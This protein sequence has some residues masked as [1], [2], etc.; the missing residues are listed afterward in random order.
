MANI[1]LLDALDFKRIYKRFKKDFAPGE[2][3]PYFVL[4]SQI[5]NG[6]QQC[7]LF[8]MD[9]RESAY[10][11]CAGNHMNE[12]VLISYLAVYKE[13]RGAGIGSAFLTEIKRNYARKKGILVEVEKP[14]C[15]K[16]F[17][18]KTIRKMRM[19]F[20]QNEG[21]QVVPGI[22]YSIWG[23]PMHLMIIGQDATSPDEIVLRIHEIYL[24]LMGERFIHMLHIRLV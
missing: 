14:E 1:V 23:V 20:Y 21:F 10:A 18:E 22:D 13:Y 9:D 17:A 8:F 15:A 11:V 4:H 6:I 3:A 19:R 16:D 2:Y 5:L 24:E 12:F 7:F